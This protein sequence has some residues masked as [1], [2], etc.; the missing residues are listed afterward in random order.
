MKTPAITY[1]SLGWGVQS[2]TIAAMV[3]LGHLKGLDIA[4]HSDTK[5]ERE[6]TYDFARRWTPWLED[7]GVTVATTFAQNTEWLERMT[8]RSPSVHIPAFTL[9]HKDQKEGQLGRQCT[10]HWKLKP[11]RS[12]VRSLLPNRRTYPGAVECWIGISLDE[13]HRMRTSD[14]KYITNRYPL[15]DLRMTRTDC[16]EWLASQGLEQPPKSAC[17]FCPFHNKRYWHDLKRAGGPDWDKAV[18][19]DRQIR[20]ARNLHDLFIH[21]ARVPLAQAVTIPEDYGAQQMELDM[22]CD[23]G[24]CFN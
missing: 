7:H 23:G 18:E 20:K 21:P 3:A 10:S 12:Y 6:G 13:W 15:V 8:E 24:V 5:H 19:V 1:L 22:P 2:F 16:A 14:V 11:L 9:A 17:G 4:I